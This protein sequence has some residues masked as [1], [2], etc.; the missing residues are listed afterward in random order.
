MLSAVELKKLYSSNEFINKYTYSNNDLGITYSREKT[1]FKIWAPTAE[2]II[3]NLYKS[4]NYKEHDFITSYE[5][6]FHRDGTWVKT[7]N[8]DLNGLY[9][10]YKVYVNG[11]INITNDPYSIAC[12]VNG[13][14]S[15]IVD[16][17]DTNPD[18]WDEDYAR[19]RNNECPVIYELHIKDFSFD[20]ASGIKDEYRG[21][22]LAFTQTGTTLNNDG[23][24]KTGIDYLKSLGI[25]HVHLL[26]CFDYG[27][28]DEGSKD[29]SQFNWGYDPVNY[30]VPE[31][32]Y[33][34]KPFDGMV[35]IKEFKEM[36][37]AIHKAGLKVVMDVVYNHTYNLDTSLQ[38]VV[39]YYYYRVNDD[40]T[41]SDGSACGNDTASDRI[42]YRNYMVNSVLYW[43]EEYHIDGFRFDLMGLHDVETM[44]AIRKALNELPDG[45][46]IIMYGEPWAAGETAMDKKAVPALK[47]NVNLLDENI[48]IFCDD[49]RDSIKGHV[50]YGEVPGFINGG[51]GFEDKIKSSV[52]AWCSGNTE[53]S[54]HSPK[55]IISYVSAH[56][57]FTLYDKLMETLR[58]IKDYNKY[59]EELIRINKLAASIVFTCQGINFFQ[60]GEE[61]ARTKQGEDNSF[62]LSPELNMIDWNRVYEY[63]GL[64]NYYKGLIKLRKNFTAL[65]S[66]KNENLERYDFIDT[67]HDNLVCYTLLN[68][69]DS[70]DIFTKLFIAYNSSLNDLNLNLPEGKWQLLVNEKRSDLF[71]DEIF[72][73][74]NISIPKQSALILG[75]K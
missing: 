63:E 52:L 9:Y 55:Q 49:T 62:D 15:M 53:Y 67:K 60:A 34:T 18:G 45:E 16:L 14:R 20:K 74:G 7:L 73:S 30:N 6:E 61:F 40:G 29:E 28:V 70:K 13:K 64:V 41:L 12:G 22:Y 75:Q 65:H 50:F 68:D 43:A 21:K 51:I 69:P 26:P 42:M 17:N 5:L 25:T 47:K 59:D 23:I 3:L 39:P 38:K 66:M 31:G 32:S 54:P 10:D 2:K 27:S 44:N 48:S 24:H 57:N 11:S 1:V 35:R 46:N 56:D 33:S 71:N 19:D 72:A 4:G 8:G 36:V 37:Q 58:E